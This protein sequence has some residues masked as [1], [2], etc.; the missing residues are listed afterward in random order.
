MKYLE[1]NQIYRAY[2]PL[3]FHTDDF[4]GSLKFNDTI[5]RV[6]LSKMACSSVVCVWRVDLNDRTNWCDR[7]MLPMSI[8]TWWDSDLIRHIASVIFAASG[9][10]WYQNWL[11]NC[12]YS[13]LVSKAWCWVFWG[14]GGM[15]CYDTVSP[16]FKW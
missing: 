14:G 4:R 2:Y 12:V 16:F 11:W 3:Q 1:D 13:P 6:K 9:V 5:F 7:Q 15:Y 10:T 8:R